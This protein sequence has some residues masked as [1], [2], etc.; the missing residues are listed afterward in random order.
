MATGTATEAAAAATAAAASV[1]PLVV[2]VEED[3]TISVAEVRSHKF[4][5]SAWIVL[6]GYVYD[7]TEFIDKHPG[8]SQSILPALGKDVTMFWSAI[9]KEEWLEQHL[10]PEWRLGRLQEPQEGEEKLEEHRGA[11]AQPA[12]VGGDVVYTAV[13][14]PK[15]LKRRQQRRQQID[16]GLTFQLQD[17]MILLQTEPA[18]KHTLMDRVVN[19]VEERGDPNCT[20]ADGVGSSTPL[21]LAANLGS[22]EHVKRLLDANADPLYKTE[23]NVTVIHKFAG[24]PMPDAVAPSVL[25]HLLN[26]QCSVNA[27]MMQGRTPL[28]VAAQWGQVDMCRLLLNRGALKNLRATD[29]TAAD[30]ARVCIRDRVKLK[31]VLKVLG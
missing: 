22:D 21:L 19:L 16:L 12:K 2:A 30:W 29:G 13:E 20:D 14:D 25:S 24:R 28:H 11:V 7:L 9:H 15:S 23:R 18:R 10:Q 8:G 4:R 5:E 1:T 3:V 26:A 17:T 31:A 6:K 27:T